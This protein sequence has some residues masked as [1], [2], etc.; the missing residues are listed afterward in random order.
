MKK[1]EH[2]AYISLF[3]NDAEGEKKPVFSG[4]IEFPDKSRHKVALWEKMSETGR[5]YYSGVVQKEVD[6]HDGP[7]PVPPSDGIKV[8]RTVSVDAGSAYS[9]SPGGDSDLPF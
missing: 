4:S 1:Y 9:A 6:A 8:G 5:M 3:K 2:V 7:A